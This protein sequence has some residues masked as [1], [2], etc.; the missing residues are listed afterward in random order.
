MNYSDKDLLDAAEILQNYLL[1]NTEEV[2]E[3]LP[4]IDDARYLILQFLD[5][6]NKRGIYNKR[7]EKCTQAQ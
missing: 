7:G 3:E 6:K 5:E 2:F 4:L 1:D